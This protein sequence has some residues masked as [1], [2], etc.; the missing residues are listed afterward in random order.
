MA[1]FDLRL[2]LG[3]LFL[4]IG[5]LLTAAGFFVSPVSSDG[6]TLGLNINLFWGVPLLFFGLICLWM[7]SRHSRKHGPSGV[8]IKP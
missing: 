3:W 7:A 5:G 6:Y 2:P 4:I 8:T 1:Y